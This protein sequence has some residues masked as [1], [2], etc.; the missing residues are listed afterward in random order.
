[1]QKALSYFFFQLPPEGLTD[2]KQKKKKKKIRL[3]NKIVGIR[4]G[5]NQG[6]LPDKVEF[7]LTITNVT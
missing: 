2:A 5:E 7:F 6:T 1:M 3:I 4:Q